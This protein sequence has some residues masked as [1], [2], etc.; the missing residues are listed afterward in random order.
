MAVHDK[1][2]QTVMA[3][4]GCSQR[5]F[6]ALCLDPTIVTFVAQSK[7]GR[8]APCTAQ[9]NNCLFRCTHEST[10]WHLLVAGAFFRVGTSGAAPSDVVASAA[11]PDLPLCAHLCCHAKAAF[12]QS[13]YATCECMLHTAHRSPWSTIM[14]AAVGGS[15]GSK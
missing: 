15:K 11:Q 13:H 10:C 4:A 6:C 9:R 8:D 7:R 3:K 2:A 5:S 12:S 14:G 1:N